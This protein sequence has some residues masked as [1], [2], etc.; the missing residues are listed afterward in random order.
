MKKRM[1]LILLAAAMVLGM[2]ACKKNG[3]G[4]GTTAAETTAVV[5]QVGTAQNATV[6]YYASHKE[7]DDWW[8]VMALVA[9]GVDVQDDGY[10]PPE[11]NEADVMT[12]GSP[13]ATAKAIL[14]LYAI[15]T[16]PRTYFNDGDLVAAL[17]AQ[18]KDSG[19]FGTYLNEQIYAIIALECA[20]GQD[21]D[22]DAAFSYLCAQS[23]AG[24]G[25]S[26]DGTTV[27]P[28]LTG[29]ALV[30]LGFNRD[31]A[32]ADRAAQNAI[33]WLAAN[34]SEG[35]GYPSAWENGAET[36]DTIST[37]ISG[38]VAYGADL[39]EEPFSNLVNNLLTYQT[40]DGGFGH[41]KQD[42]EANACSTYQALLALDSLKNG[43]SAY[44]YFK[45]GSEQKNDEPTASFQITGPDGDL[46]AGAQIDVTDGETVF[47]GIKA[48]CEANGIDIVSSGTGAFAYISAIGGL[49]EFDKGPSS[50]WVYAVNGVYATAG[51]GSMKL[52]PDDYVWFYY[53]SD[54]G[55]DFQA[56]LSGE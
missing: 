35:G 22:R 24:G 38:L 25:F 40:P 2:A 42:K 44:E 3:S 27:D 29:M 21:Y 53:S 37:V 10:T 48:A 23:L 18:Q 11:L 32:A 14:A 47:E 20:G 9:A 1:V 4:N 28:D 33:T 39:T 51:A 43:K 8:Q 7:L 34:I 13:A 16:D 56:I 54:L 50:G 26:Y 5:D 17:A 45:A 49:K 41:T 19:E 46:L 6:S 30:A 52:K 36:S 12:E 55:A 15:G 31:N